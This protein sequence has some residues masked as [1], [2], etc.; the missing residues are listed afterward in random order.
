MKDEGLTTTDEGLTTTHE[1]LIM[2]DEGLIM[3]DACRILVEGLELPCI[4][5][6][7]WI[8]LVT[9]RSTSLLFGAYV[10]SN[11][12]TSFDHYRCSK[13]IETVKLTKGENISNNKKSSL[14]ELICFFTKPPHFLIVINDFSSF[15]TF[16]LS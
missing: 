1:G 16:L 4:T 10:Q 8:F 7:A 13:C 14:A 12:V 5:I 3:T 9:L 15:A 11:A 6:Q 2:T